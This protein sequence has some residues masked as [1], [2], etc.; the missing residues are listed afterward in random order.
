MRQC[1]QQVALLVFTY[2]FQPNISLVL[3]MPSQVDT[4][5]V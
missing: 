5:G 4:Y 3:R 2:H 1:D